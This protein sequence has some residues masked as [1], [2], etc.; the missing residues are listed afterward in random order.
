[1]R[2]ISSYDVKKVKFSGDKENLDPASAAAE[3]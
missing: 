2:D 3:Q 1:M